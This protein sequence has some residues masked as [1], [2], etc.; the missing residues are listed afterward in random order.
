MI[1]HDTPE[2][3]STD[4]SRMALDLAAWGVADPASL[5]LLDPPPAA[6]WRYARELLT[7]FGAIDA[8]GRITAHGRALGRLPTSPRLAHLLLKAQQS[9]QGALA[10]WLAAA[11]AGR[12]I[13]YW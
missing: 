12:M 5:R 10:C 3:L 1:A 6:N 2:M 9:G 8:A 7:S 13:G 4:L 11:S